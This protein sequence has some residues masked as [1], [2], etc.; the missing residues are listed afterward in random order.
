[1]TRKTILIVDDDSIFR[2]SLT[3]I[4]NRA[5]YEAH[6]ARSAVSGRPIFT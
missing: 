6:T 4:L 3:D 1:M 5:G 2:T